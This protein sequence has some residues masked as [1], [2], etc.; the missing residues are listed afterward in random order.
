[1]INGTFRQISGVFIGLKKI[2]ARRNRVVK[3]VRVCISGGGKVDNCPEQTNQ[4][5][6]LTKFKGMIVSIAM[7]VIAAAAA[8]LPSYYYTLGPTFK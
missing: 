4:M 1:M 5:K 3:G 7:I 8:Q 6:S 2:C